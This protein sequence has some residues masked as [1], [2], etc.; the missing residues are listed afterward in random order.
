[1]SVSLK[2]NWSLERSYYIRVSMS[3]FIVLFCWKDNQAAAPQPGE[4]GHRE[5]RREMGPW[6]HH[7]RGRSESP[8]KAGVFRHHEFH[9]GHEGPPPPAFFREHGGPPMRHLLVKL[10][11]LTRGL[12]QNPSKLLE[13]KKSLLV[14][15]LNLMMLE[16]KLRVLKGDISHRPHIHL[17]GID[18]PPRVHP[19]MRHHRMHPPAPDGFFGHHHRR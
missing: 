5:F 16:Y 3:F 19:H 18:E 8:H 2:Q 11:A 9:R 17:P 1:M 15:S 14:L 12:A 6:H 7:E 13:L 10:G 4:P